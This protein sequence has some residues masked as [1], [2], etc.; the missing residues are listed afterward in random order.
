MWTTLAVSSAPLPSVFISCC[1]S[2]WMC[3]CRKPL[4]SLIGGLMMLIRA[5][6]G[7]GTARQIRPACGG[8][9]ERAPPPSQEAGSETSDPAGFH[10][11]GGKAEGDRRARAGGRSGEAGFTEL[12]LSAVVFSNLQDTRVLFPPGPQPRHGKAAADQPLHAQVEAG[13]LI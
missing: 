7:Q 2:L 9:Q 13:L 1:R 5:C 4:G 3:C 6:R 12:D 8:D 10:R 11:R